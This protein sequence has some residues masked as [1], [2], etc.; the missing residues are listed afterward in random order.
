MGGVINI[1]IDLKSSAK[2][3]SEI[4]ENGNGYFDFSSKPENI[5][6][7]IMDLWA[8]NVI[9]AIVSQS[10]KGQ[11]HIEYVVGRWSM[12]D[13]LLEPNVF[14]I[15]TTRMRICGKGEVNFNTRKLKLE[16]APAPKKPE[17]FS[18]ATPVNVQGDFSDFGLGI[19]PGGLIGTG[20]KF[21]ISP[22][23]VTL[24]TIFDKPIPADGSDLWPIK[25]GQENRKTKP[26][27]G[28]RGW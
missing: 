4:L 24:Q 16:V 20:I 21:V 3:F 8:I 5:E 6:S 22:I 10:V 17:F 13:G 19:A 1:D 28:C 27:V 23:Q 9:S 12:E 18:L 2:D 7:G 15:D 26:P 11:S 25:L 14:V